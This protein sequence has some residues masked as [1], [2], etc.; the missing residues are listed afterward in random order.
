[1]SDPALVREWAESV[2]GRVADD[3]S[4]QESQSKTPLTTQDG[5]DVPSYYAADAQILMHGDSALLLFAR[6]HPAA[7]PD[8]NIAPSALRNPV[9]MIGMNVRGLAD[10]SNTIAAVIQQIENQGQESHTNS[11]AGKQDGSRLAEPGVLPKDDDEAASSPTV[12]SKRRWLG[13][14]PLLGRRTLESIISRGAVQTAALVGGF[15]LIM[16]LW[17]WDATLMIRAADENARLLKAGIELV[18][19]EWASKVDSA[20]RSFGADRAMLFIEAVAMVKLIMVLLAHP[21]QRLR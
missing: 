19:L 20:L 13:G 18:S 4:I 3:A 12:P 7:L 6:P 14:L 8:R 16:A 11:S 21:F 5:S 15:G 1:V 2:N 10:L 17:Y 9:A